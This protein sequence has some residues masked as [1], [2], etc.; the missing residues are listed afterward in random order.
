[1]LRSCRVVIVSIPKL[2]KSNGQVVFLEA[3]FF[4]E[5]V[6]G[7]GYGWKKREYPNRI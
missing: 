1:L 7:D 5:A 6:K 2:V 3:K 4:W